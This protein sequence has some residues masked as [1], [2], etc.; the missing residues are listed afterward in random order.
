[1]ELKRK[2]DTGSSQLAVDTKAKLS[3]G[4]LTL[5]LV[6]SGGILGGDWYTFFGQEQSAKSTLAMQCVIA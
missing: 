5:D 1:M 6:L 3:I 2:Y 4:L